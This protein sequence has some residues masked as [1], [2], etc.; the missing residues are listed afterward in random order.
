M[1]LTREEIIALTQTP[2]KVEKVGVPGVGEFHLKV[3]TGSER[4]SYRAATLSVEGDKLKTDFR[5]MD[6]ALLV[7]T[8]CDAGGQRLFTDA[9]ANL[10]G[11]LPSPIVAALAA[12]AGKLNAL[13]EDAVGQ[14]EKNLL[15]TENST[16]GT[17]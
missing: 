3:M 9:D 14:A 6:V 13:N 10:V 11:K 1:A 5:Q 2:A 16:S 7:R 4:G 12:A 15:P 8:L 17:D